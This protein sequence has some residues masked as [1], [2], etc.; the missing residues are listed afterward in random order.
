VIGVAL[1]AVADGRDGCHGCGAG[2][3]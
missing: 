2:G 3:W 1:R